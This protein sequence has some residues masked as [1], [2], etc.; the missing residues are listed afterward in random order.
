MEVTRGDVVAGSYGHV[1][2]LLFGTPLAMM[3]ER[4]L[5]IA[6]ALA[7]RMRGEPGAAV[8][9]GG[10]PIA[11]RLGVKALSDGIAHLSIAGT[12]TSKGSNM[13]AVSGLVGYDALTD[14]L[15][16]LAADPNVRGVAVE[17]DSPGGAVAGVTE[18]VAAMRVLAE[19]K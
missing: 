6:E 17:M 12:L 8:N 11:N 13:D 2:S 10:G 4:A 16:A 19:R 1:A 15:T 3:P 5:E 9:V 18:A 7:A 14:S